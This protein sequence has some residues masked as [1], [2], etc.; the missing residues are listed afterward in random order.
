MPAPNVYLPQL[1]QIRPQYTTGATDEPGTPEN[2]TWWQG[3]TAGSFPLTVSQL[4]LIAAAFDPAW[5]A[6]W[7][8]V[9]S[10]NFFYTGSIIT[11][12]STS[13]GAQVSTVG[14]FAGVQGLATGFAPAQTALLISKKSAG[15]PKY[16]GGH[17]RT[18][19]PFLG[20]SI[21]NT[22]YEANSVQ[23]GNV[24]ADYNN[25]YTA[26]NGVGTINGGPFAEFV[27]RKRHDPVHAAIYGVTHVTVQ[28]RFATQRRRMRKAPHH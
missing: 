14:V 15:M 11:D 17:P 28:G 12:W 13:T 26:M 24:Q 4:T 8:H 18:Y 6:M 2:V 27:F 1:I 5:G 25:L 20:A 7:K 3:G 23:V 22:E 16:R 10:Q 9:G 19:L 21:I